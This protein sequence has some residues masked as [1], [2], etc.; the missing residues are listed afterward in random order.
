LWDALRQSKVVGVKV[1]REVAVSVAHPVSYAV[2]DRVL[3]T[4]FIQTKATPRTKTVYRVSFQGFVTCDH[5]TPFFGG[6]L[7]LTVNHDG[8]NRTVA[9]PARTRTLFLKPS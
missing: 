9:T 2:V 8:K 6:N 3:Q 7:A 1:W 5:G 4:Y